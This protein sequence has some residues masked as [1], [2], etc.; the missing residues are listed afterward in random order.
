[1]DGEPRGWIARFLSSLRN[2]R[3][4]SAHTEAAYR[5]DLD[6]LTAYATAEGVADW[7]GLDNYH[8]RSFAAA[9]HRGGLSPRSVQRR[10]SAARSFFE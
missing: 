5:R 7:R 8:L 6:R 10:L 1:M 9:E 4:Y 2:E 3:R